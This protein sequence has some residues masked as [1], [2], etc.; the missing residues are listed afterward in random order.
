MDS[1][2]R[3]DVQIERLAHKYVLKQ[4]QG[5]GHYLTIQEVQ[6]TF[7]KTSIKCQYNKTRQ[8]STFA[9]LKETNNLSKLSSR[10]ETV[11]TPSMPVTIP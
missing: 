7:S 4:S 5:R 1:I 11:L 9:S 3:K 10:D 2:I 8:D 6:S